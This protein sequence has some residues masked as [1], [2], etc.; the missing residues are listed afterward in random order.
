[1]RKVR[2]ILLLVFALLLTYL[3]AE[4]LLLIQSNYRCDECTGELVI[5]FMHGYLSGKQCTDQQSTVGGWL[6]GH[7]ELEVDSLVYGFEFA[8]RERIHY[9]ARQDSAVFNSRFTRKPREAWQRET[10]AEKITSI[11]IPIS[12][13]QKQE[14]L[15]KMELYHRQAPYDYALFGMR[16]ASTAYALLAEAGILPRRPRM[17]YELNAFYQ[18]QLRKRL[19]PWA[20][21]NGLVVQTRDGIDCRSWE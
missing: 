17:A 12:D 6:G 5:H 10:A 3:L 13:Q 18:R 11:R 4:Y 15:G 21:R 7:I 2:R 19:V 20:Q 1:M 9:F 16:C 8:D 14:L